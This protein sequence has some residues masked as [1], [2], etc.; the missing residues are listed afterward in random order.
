MNVRKS[1]CYRATTDTPPI[2]ILEHPKEIYKAP[3]TE[4]FVMSGSGERLRREH[5]GGRGPLSG[6]RREGAGS[7]RVRRWVRVSVGKEIKRNQRRPTL[8][9]GGTH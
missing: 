7:A 3:V 4:Q 8:N 6:R 1:A 9:A 5:A 2:E